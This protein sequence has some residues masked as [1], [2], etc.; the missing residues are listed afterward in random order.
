V[1]TAAPGCP[2]ERSSAEQDPR[3]AVSST[4]WPGRRKIC[5]E[6]KGRDMLTGEESLQELYKKKQTLEGEL[7]KLHG[8]DRKEKQDYIQ[9]IDNAIEKL[10]KKPRSIDVLY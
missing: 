4:L 1:G 10:K 9:D 2:A 7:E 8:Q 6:G 3:K 5:E